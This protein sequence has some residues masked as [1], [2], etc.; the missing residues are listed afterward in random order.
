MQCY[1]MII[2]S[3]KPLEIQ[4]FRFACQVFIQID[5]IYEILRIEGMTKKALFKEFFFTIVQHGQQ[6]LGVQDEM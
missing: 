3:A 6:T 1:S 2:L 5:I 4:N